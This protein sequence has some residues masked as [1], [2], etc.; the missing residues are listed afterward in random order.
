MVSINSNPSARGALA[1]LRSTIANRDDAQMRVITGYRVAT[2]S[3]DAAYWSIATTIRG[4][5]KSL[6][7]VEDSLG[8]AAAVTDT[9]V[10]GMQQSVDI[11]SEIKA[12]LVAARE[13]GSDRAKIDADLTELKA[14]LK[15]ISYSSSFSGQNWLTRQSTAEDAD[16]NLVGGFARQQDGQIAILKLTY[17]IGG[18]AGTTNVNF[19]VDDVDGSRGILTSNAFAQALGTSKN[20]V[21]A[22]SAGGPVQDEIKL[23][24]ATTDQDVSEMISV[25]DAMEQRAITVASTIGA[26]SKS[27]DLQ[28]DFSA[29]LKTALASGVGKMVDANMDEESG[30]IRALRVREQLGQEG[31]AIANTSAD[32]VLQ[33]LK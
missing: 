16:R 19:M 7:A 25:V 26:L 4:D 1:I 31:L 8:M 21:L 20:W 3:D 28:H 5:T 2:A 10:N 30:R 12:R 24:N 9:A 15:S 6:S 27:V 17:A 22:Q 18:Q 11:L 23:T 33:L 13:P 14:Q 29:S 32:A